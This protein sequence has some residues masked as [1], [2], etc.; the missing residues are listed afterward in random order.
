MCKG[1]GNEFFHLECIG[2]KAGDPSLRGWICDE[3]KKEYSDSEPWDSLLTCISRQPANPL[4]P[5]PTNELTESTS[6]E[7]V[8]SSPTILGFT[9]SQLDE[10]VTEI[11]GNNDENQSPAKAISLKEPQPLPTTSNSNPASE[12]PQPG[13]S[14]EKS[15]E[16]SPQTSNRPKQTAK[17]TPQPV[18]RSDAERAELE[19]M[20]QEQYLIRRKRREEEEQAKNQSDNAEPSTSSLNQPTNENQETAA[21]EETTSGEDTSSED[22][23]NDQG[24][25]QTRYVI[26]SIVDHGYYNDGTLGYRV[27][28]LGYDEMTWEKEKRFDRAYRILE[29]YK[30]KAD[31]GPPT[32]KNLWGSTDL[33][34]TNPRIWN[35]P[36][37]VIQAVRGYIRREHRDLLKIKIIKE[38]DELEPS[39]HLYLIDYGNHGLVGLHQVDANLITV[40]DGGNS[41]MEDEDV[42]NWIHSWIKVP[43]R[44]V[45]FPHQSKIDHCS[46]SAVAICIRFIQLY[47]TGTAI[48]SPLVVPRTLHEKLKRT[49]HKGPSVGLNG[50]K[51]IQDNMQKFRCNHPGCNYISRRRNQRQLAAHIKRHQII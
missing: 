13:T 25:S 36:D 31:L 44:P 40:A 34:Q 47:A 48:P 19:R 18:E 51:A 35:S 22:N 20:F 2:K 1:D 4:Q 24:E 43:I 6:T 26:E 11:L 32:F 14:K 46:S 29:T 10:A 33:E 42:R 41:Y 9:A 30:R 38:G 27:K 16:P 5:Q 37:T 28:W 12:E 8:E 3:C 39:D 15:T 50:W 49:M 23:E 45:E 17:R 21:N 7:V